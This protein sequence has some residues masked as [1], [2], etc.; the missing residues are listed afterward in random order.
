MTFTSPLWH[1]WKFA[2]S[3][4]FIPNRKR[5]KIRPLNNIVISTRMEAMPIPSTGL[6]L[7]E[8]VESRVNQYRSWY[9]RKAISCKNRYLWMRAFTV[10]AGG[11]VPVLVNVEDRVNGLLGYHIT[12]VVVTIVSLLVV[13]TVS[14]ESVFH[15]RE[16]WKNYRSTEQMLGREQFE[17]LARVGVYK[18]LPLDGAFQLFVERIEAAISSENAATLNVMAIGS[19]T[20]GQRSK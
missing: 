3:S 14:L 12:K 2:N 15:Y 19:E 17:L 18:A 11:V 5:A 13:V 7:D 6:S 1:V 8:Y 20:L 16:Q 4:L 10:I 9:D